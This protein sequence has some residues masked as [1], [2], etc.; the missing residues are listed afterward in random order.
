MIW[1]LK[2]SPTASP[3]ATLSPKNFKTVS[4]WRFVFQKTGPFSPD[5]GGS[6]CL[7]RDF[8]PQKNHWLQLHTVGSGAEFLIY[9]FQK[10]FNFFLKF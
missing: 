1:P 8:S 4:I 2:L 3:V 10:Q 9:F 7:F 6:C 5:F